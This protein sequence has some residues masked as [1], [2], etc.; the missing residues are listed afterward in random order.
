MLLWRTTSSLGY[1]ALERMDGGPFPAVESWL[2]GSDVTWKSYAW[3]IL[4]WSSFQIM[5]RWCGSSCWWPYVWSPSYDYQGQSSTIWYQLPQPAQ[6]LASAS[7]LQGSCIAARDHELSD[8]MPCQTSSKG[9]ASDRAHLHPV[10]GSSVRWK[11]F[12]LWNYGR[13]A[14]NE[15]TERAKGGYWALVLKF[16]SSND[17]EYWWKM[18]A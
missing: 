1:P 5:V 17:G 4:T 12:P 18:N 8:S 15:F 13:G 14:G 6:I 16:L 3:I 2:S 9:G 11:E 7:D 10:P